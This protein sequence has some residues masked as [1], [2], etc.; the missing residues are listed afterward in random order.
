MCASNPLGSPCTF[1]C[2]LP[3]LMR[4]VCISRCCQW[5]FK[6]SVWGWHW[7]A[8]AVGAGAK[9]VPVQGLGS[10]DQARWCRAHVSHAAE[11]AGTLLPLEL[12]IG[13]S[14]ST[15]VPHKVS[16]TVSD[17]PKSLLPLVCHLPWDSKSG[18]K[19][20]GSRETE[21][22]VCFSPPS[23]Y[24]ASLPS[25]WIDRWQKG[26][27]SLSRPRQNRTELL[28]RQGA[29]QIHG[30]RVCGAECTLGGLQRVVKYRWAIPT[31]SHP[32]LPCLW[33]SCVCE[34]HFEQ[35]SISVVIQWVSVFPSP[36]VMSLTFI[37][38]S[39]QSFEDCGCF[40]T[41]KMKLQY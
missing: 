10:R 31:A 30:Q 33:Q 17:Q 23:P 24:S 3:V 19:K 8:Q 37:N 36:V 13:T 28:L 25:A 35:A 14:A 1:T 29:V 15:W 2:C 40:M 7:E 39:D 20:A 4:K 5:V 12:C 32:G 21:Q 34:M 18:V 11:G 26:H 6:R 9:V 22:A 41:F 27:L 16:A 38:L